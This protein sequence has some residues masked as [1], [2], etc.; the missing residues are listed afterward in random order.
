MAVHGDSS[1][2]TAGTAFFAAALGAGGVV[3]GAVARLE[4][5][6]T[7]AAFV[8]VGVVVPA[9]PVV[10]AT[11][12]G[13]AFFAGAFFGGVFLAGAFFGA[14]LLGEGFF[15]AAFFGAA[16]VGAAFFAAAF[17]GAAALA[18]PALTGTVFGVFA[19]RA[20]ALAAAFF[21][22]EAFFAAVAVFTAAVFG[23]DLVVATFFA[24]TA[25]AG[26]A[27][28][29]TAFAGTAFDAPALFRAAGAPA[30][31]RTPFAGSFGDDDLPPTA[32]RAEAAAAAPT[33]LAA[34]SA[35]LTMVFPLPGVRQ[36]PSARPVRRGYGLHLPLST[37]KRRT[38]PTHR[39]V[40]RRRA[41]HAAGPFVC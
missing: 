36:A 10:V 39:L 27:F 5:V 40:T 38:T 6:V 41:R 28:A 19:D 31:A 17:V 9:R 3:D 30:A 29:G 35:P 33:C 24:G 2:R 1:S 4:G 12:F 8:D 23:P 26:T 32:L 20:G 14:E 37:T 13:A 7:D 34:D 11:F 21:V 15:A 22:A 18:A 16:F 25:F